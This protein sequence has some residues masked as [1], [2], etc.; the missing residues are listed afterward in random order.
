MTTLLSSRST[1]FMK[2]IFPTIWGA[3]WSYA[4]ARL[5]LEPSTTVS[6]SPWAKWM[7]LGFLVMGGVLFRRVAFP[8]KRVILEDDVLRI[9]NYRQEIRVPIGRVRSAGFD[10]GAE[11][12]NR[13]LIGIEFDGPTSFGRSIEF[14]PRSRDA[15]DLL[16]ARL[17]PK[18]G[19]PPA[20]DDD[21]L[22]A[23][24]RGRG[25]V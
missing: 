22:A 24:L 1:F 6:T 2:F 23:E 25:T 7:F 19:G 21:A 8:L 14:M 15:V 9:S 16:R 3:G 20:K 18:I 5:F 11:I 4:T 13:S 12:N 10:P 17:G